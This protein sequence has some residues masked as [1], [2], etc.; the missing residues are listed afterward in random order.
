MRPLIGS[1]IHH[2]TIDEGSSER[3]RRNQSLQEEVIRLLGRAG[4]GGR[5]FLTSYAERERQAQ[6]DDFYKVTLDLL[7]S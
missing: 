2:Y 5:T 6:I 7:I 3:A 1:L 4:R